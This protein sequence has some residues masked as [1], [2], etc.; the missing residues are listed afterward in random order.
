MENCFVPILDEL[1]TRE[2]ALLTW[3]NTQGYFGE[4]ELV[5]LVEGIIGDD[6]DA[7]DVIDEMVA[8]G[9]MVSWSDTDSGEEHYRTRMAEG[10]R[11][12]STLRQMFPKHANG[13]A[14]KQAATLVSDYRFLRRKRKYPQRNVSTETVI[15]ALQSDVGLTTGESELLKDLLR[16]D[17]GY[18][19]LAEFQK[20]ACITVLG[21]VRRREASGSI[22][23][24]GTG[25]GKT[26]AFY[27]PALTHI[28]NEKV[29]GRGG[30]V[31]ALAIYPRNELLKDQFIETWRQV[32]KLDGKLARAKIRIGA[33]F[34]MAPANSRSITTKSRGWNKVPGGV[35]CEYIP[36][37]DEKCTGRMVWLDTQREQ[38]I[39]RLSCEMCSSAIEPDEISLTRESM[40]KSPPDLL[41]TSTEMLNRQMGNPN[42]RHI[43]GIGERVRAP[44]MM[45]LDEVHTY[46]GV[47]GAQV[48]M[49]LR[50][51]CHLAKATPHFVGL[52]ATLEQAP[53]FFASLTGLPDHSVMEVSP[54][55]AEMEQ[56]GAEY[57]LALRGDPASSS[58]LLSTT[59]QTSMLAKRIMDEGRNPKSKGLFGTRSFV[60][61][62]DIDV[63]NRLYFQLLDAE[64][65]Y[66]NGNINQTKMPLASLRSPMNADDEQF[67]FGQNWKLVNQIG[68]SLDTV[69]RA[70]IKRTS[71][72]DAGVD[73]EADV[74]VATASLE[75]GFND[76]TVGA[77][78]QHKAPRD[79]AQ[80]LQRKGRAGRQR[81]MRP[82]TIV[83][84]SDYGRDRMAFQSY[85]DLFNPELKARRLPVHNSYV[86]R[87]QAAFA[88]MDWL[89]Q[90][91]KVASSLSYG[92]LWN[93]L[94]C[95]QKNPKRQ[96]QVRVEVEEVLG[97]RTRASELVE[98]VSNAL[99]LNSSNPEHNRLLD[100]LFW[101]PPR[102][103]MTS[104]L[105]TVLRRLN[106][107]WE[108]NGVAGSDNCRD[109]APMPEFV[110]SALFNDLCLPELEINFSA[111]NQYQND[112]APLMPILQGMRDFAPGRVSKRF[113]MD[114]IAQKHWVIPESFTQPVAGDYPFPI[115]EYC[116]LERL[117][118]MGECLIDTPTGVA[119]IPC[120]RPYEVKASAPNP[121]WCLLDTTQGFLNWHTEIRPPEERNSA[122]TPMRNAWS[123]IL[124]GV[125]FFTHHKHCPVE[126]IRL[127]TGSKAELKF[128]GDTPS[129]TVNFEFVHQD[130][131]ASLAFALWVDAVA[132]RWKLPELDMMALRQDSAL[133]AALRTARFIDEVRNDGTLTDNVFL[134]GWLAESMLA[135]LC[136]EAMLSQCSIK[137]ALDA[138]LNGTAQVELNE[139]PRRIFQTL[140]GIAIEDGEQDLQQNL[141]ELLGRA[142]VITKLAKWAELLWEQ[143]DDSWQSWIQRCFQ[144]TLGGALQ[145]TALQ[146]CQ[147][148]DEQ[149][150]VLDLDPGPARRAK[151]SKDEMEIWLSETTVGGGGVIERIQQAYSE[152]PKRFFELLEFNLRAGD[153]EV[154]DNHIFQLLEKLKDQSPLTQRMQA[155]RQ[156]SDY[157]SQLNAQNAL[158]A[159]LQQTGFMTS[160][161]FMSAVN[162]RLLRPKSGQQQDEMLYELQANWRAEETRL[163][164]EV[165]QR[166]YAFSCS[167]NTQLDNCLPD[168]NQVKGDLQTW[169]FNVINGLLWP[170]G[171]SVRD[172]HLTY[173]NPYAF[174]G[175]TERLLVKFFT[176]ETCA[177]VS[178]ADEKWLEACH[179][180]L[181]LQGRCELIAS[182]DQEVSHALAELLVKPVDM[183]GL[184]FYPRVSAVR[185]N[186]QELYIQL[187][188]VE[189]IQ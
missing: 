41:F 144:N 161:S 7:Y 137:Q 66:S 69:D 154:M 94:S 79:N 80:F 114:H 99:G 97:D 56:E 78:I 38:G 164:I 165:P 62:D 110:P 129:A 120:F 86:M 37:P 9:L 148:A 20:R 135:G 10:V 59:I 63:I 131:P 40:H 111:V 1:E 152:N 178:Y 32:R 180:T 72:Q 57:M 130:K 117:D 8:K 151:L 35:V 12:F 169:R 67:E 126:V 147:D 3:G 122:E 143:P 61:T 70:N 106:T 48:G 168:A 84:L 16:H 107:H 188:I 87:I 11:L 91:P 125:D 77:V 36:C 121:E 145:Q 19:D 28:A 146:L 134:G 124:N 141:I 163:G 95:P 171:Y 81:K 149:D 55:E 58:S 173:Y 46:S 172:A 174:A 53:R 44:S 49:L 4:D 142:D 133:L 52:S 183:Y 113:A 101:Q 26:L 21:G 119:A 96:Q 33:Y 30:Y 138:L 18:Y 83:V 140:P 184:F 186:Q 89:S 157:Q 14:W 74:I 189:A 15:A 150:I 25:S 105:P 160:H 109:D 92:G 90:R 103:I 185:R 76:P 24:A 82:W 167:L 115:T 75:V 54:T 5:E 139:I 159:T 156:A 27:L 45:L 34:G 162:T 71:S 118:A 175:P 42:N 100:S 22:V 104:F 43:F 47:G 177:T 153:Y 102:A 182:T 68:H 98:F 23:C 108:K 51:W 17:D 64:G 136:C 128:Q 123:N 60:F 31:Q 85:E 88:T 170:R 116:S 179:Q 132:F 73:Q 176:G 29:A 166:V 181:E 39:E 158:L 13:G 93:D 6:E 187:E 127:T 155:M 65:R 112:D 50:R 2:S